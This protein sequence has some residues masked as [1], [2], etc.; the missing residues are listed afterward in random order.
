MKKTMLLA[1]LL[2]VLLSAGSKASAEQTIPIEIIEQTEPSTR[3]LP[4]A[5][6]IRCAYH[7]TQQ[8]LYLQVDADLGSVCVSIENLA[9]GFLFQDT[10]ATSPGLLVIPLN[11]ASGSFLITITTSTGGAY[12]ALF[13]L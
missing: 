13:Y 7:V 5:V 8:S 1:A 4:G 2:L 10:L 12:Y 6:P 11:G 3:D 9:G